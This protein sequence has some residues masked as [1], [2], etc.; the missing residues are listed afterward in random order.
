MDGREIVT[1]NGF[2]KL[3]ATLPADRTKYG[4]AAISDDSGSLL[5]SVRCLGKS[6]SLAATQHNN[7]TRNPLLPFGDIPTGQYR[8]V[9]SV[10]HQPTHSYGP[11]PVIVLNVIAGDCVTAE[12]NGRWGILI[13]GGDLAGDN[14]NLRPTH[15]CLRLDNSSM[16]YLNSLGVKEIVV[17]VTE[18]AGAVVVPGVMP[19]QLPT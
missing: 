19:T 18:A 9:F 12:D 4:V 16:A 10:I 2:V 14:I 11:Y 8:G 1:G 15:G 6:D 3:L 7:P 13:H 17:E 5:R